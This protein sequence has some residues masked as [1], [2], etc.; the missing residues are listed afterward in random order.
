MT[1]WLRDGIEGR[2]L[3]AT[4]RLY[5]FGLMALAA[6]AAALALILGDQASFQVTPA[7]VLILVTVELAFCYRARLRKDLG[8]LRRKTPLRIGQKPKRSEESSVTLILTASTGD[9]N[10][11]V[12]HYEEAVDK[13]LHKALYDDDMSIRASAVGYLAWFNDPRVVEFLISA[14]QKGASSVRDAAAVALM[15]IGDLRAVESLVTALADENESVR[16][17]AA[18]ALQR[19]SSLPTAKDA[20]GPKVIQSIRRVIGTGGSDEAPLSKNARKRA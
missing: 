6:A 5:L 3:K 8:E 1:E 4:L 12:D 20:L 7:L 19:L 11:T 18:Q 9:V 16:T 10:M 17:S 14:L 15:S 13:L 2:S